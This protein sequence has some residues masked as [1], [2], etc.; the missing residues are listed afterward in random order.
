MTVPRFSAGS[1][2]N[3]VPAIAQSTKTGGRRGGKRA[4]G[5]G[6]RNGEG[7]TMPRRQKAS[8]RERPRRAVEDVDLARSDFEGDQGAGRRSRSPPRGIGREASARTGGADVSRQGSG[9]AW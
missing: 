4:S 2:A 3:A 6:K 7:Q 1:S 9:G 8:R 5:Q